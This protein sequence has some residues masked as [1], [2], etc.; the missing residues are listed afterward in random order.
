L[1]IDRPETTAGQEEN[2]RQQLAVAG[3]VSETAR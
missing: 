2:A 3:P 1:R